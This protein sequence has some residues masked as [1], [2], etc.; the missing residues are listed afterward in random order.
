M[1]DDIR[2]WYKSSQQVGFIINQPAVPSSSG[3]PG[4]FQHEFF[5]VCVCYTTKN[6]QS[7]AEIVCPQIFS[8]LHFTLFSPRKE[9]I[10]IFLTRPSVSD[11]LHYS[12]RRLPGTNS[13]TKPLSPA[14]PTRLLGSLSNVIRM[15][16]SAEENI[17]T[18]AGRLVC[19]WCGRF[20]AAIWSLP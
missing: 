15:R 16:A 4:W 7:V 19:C 3:A 17:E 14:P 1:K 12:K 13:W 20:E 2:R 6:R 18:R 10:I 11:L 5:C 8:S 9:S